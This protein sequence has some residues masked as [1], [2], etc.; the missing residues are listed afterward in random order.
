MVIIVMIFLHLAYVFYYLAKIY[1]I[2]K[3][4]SNNSERNSLAD[5]EQDYYGSTTNLLPKRPNSLPTYE[6]AIL[7]VWILQENNFKIFF[8]TF[9]KKI[10]VIFY[11]VY[12]RK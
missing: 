11:Y 9:L 6:E 2:N 1:K 12:K 7:V 8:L 10:Y 3:T 4:Y 5:S